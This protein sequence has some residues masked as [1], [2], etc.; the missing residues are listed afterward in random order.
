MSR[1]HALAR[2]I[3]R[4]LPKPLQATPLVIGLELARRRGWLQPP[5]SIDGRVVRILVEDLGLEIDVCCRDGRFTV[6]RT[7]AAEPELTLRAN[8]RDFL[9][10]A[11]GHADTDTLF[12]QR[13]LVIGGDTELGLEVKYWLDALPRPPVLVKLATLFDAAAAN[14][15][16]R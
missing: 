4:T 3:H 13:R 10:L 2:R 15:T 8:A 14:A 16:A 7:R 1:L 11:L 9:A 5:P 12:F 6:G